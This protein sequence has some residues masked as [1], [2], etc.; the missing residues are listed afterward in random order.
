RMAGKTTREENEVL[1]RTKGNWSSRNWFEPGRMSYVWDENNDERSCSVFIDCVQVMLSHQL[2]QQI[3]V[4]RNPDGDENLFRKAYAVA[5]TNR[6][7]EVLDT[8]PFYRRMRSHF[9][10]YALA[11]ILINRQE[12]RRL[13]DTGVLHENYT[14]MR[15]AVPTKWAAA[16]KKVPYI[17]NPNQTY[18]TCGGGTANYTKTAAS[19]SQQDPPTTTNLH[20]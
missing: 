17:N 4:N 12:W 5:W 8:E 9:R 11:K 7:D 19:T 14:P 2:T 1:D 13:D 15:R 18:I 20:A 16:I 6:M 10:L 3:D